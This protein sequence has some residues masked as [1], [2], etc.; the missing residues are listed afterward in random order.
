MLMP[1]ISDSYAQ[2]MVKSA[3]KRGLPPTVG[4]I[5]S[6]TP[7]DQIAPR[8][9]RSAP[10]ASGP[11]PQAAP[12]AA[13]TTTSAPSASTGLPFAARVFGMAQRAGR[14]AGT[15][16]KAARTAGTAMAAGYSRAR[17]GAAAA[18][19]TAPAPG[20]IAATLG[21]AVG[22]GAGYAVRGARAVAG[23]TPGVVRAVAPAVSRAAGA[24]KG[25][26]GSALTGAADLAFGGRKADALRAAQAGGDAADS[27]ARRVNLSA[28]D[29]AATSPAHAEK[30]FNQR[31]NVDAARTALVG[32]RARAEAGASWGTRLR[33]WLADRRDRKAS[34]AA[35]RPAVPAA[36]PAAPAL[37]PS[38]AVAGHVAGNL[39]A[40]G[41]NQNWNRPLA[42]GAAGVG[43]LMLARSMFGNRDE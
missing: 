24:V 40:R 28:I 4:S 36:S 27:A 9:P 1:T 17:G 16:T 7:A 8:I 20:G 6:V 2:V 41:W 42:L 30:I 37:N 25:G 38:A 43:G 12:S 5:P 26:I 22:A 23:A 33:A 18:P 3:A 39:P 34:A 21:G 32:E 15:A 13:S 35:G 29:Q 10:P 31:P 14:A 19:A 11:A